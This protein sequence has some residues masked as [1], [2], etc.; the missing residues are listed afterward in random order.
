MVAMVPTLTRLATYL[1][2]PKP[3]PA[4][5]EEELARRPYNGSAAP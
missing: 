1:I 5:M 2:P 4:A 3:V